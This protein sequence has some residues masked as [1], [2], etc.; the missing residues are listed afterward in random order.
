[1]SDHSH[2]KHKHSKILNTNGTFSAHIHE[3]RTLHI[4]TLRSRAARY[5]TYPNVDCRL[6]SHSDKDFPPPP[7]RIRPKRLF[8]DRCK[9]SSL[10]HSPTRA[11]VECFELIIKRFWLRHQSLWVTML[12]GRYFVRKGLLTTQPRVIRRSKRTL[13]VSSSTQSDKLTLR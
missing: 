9:H 5:V 11:V 6:L 2:V 10:S 3:E 7:I 1:M 4:I 8:S 13:C 12:S